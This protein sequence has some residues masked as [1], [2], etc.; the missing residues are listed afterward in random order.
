MVGH[1]SLINVRAGVNFDDSIYKRVDTEDCDGV[2][3]LTVRGVALGQSILD[4]FPPWTPFLGSFVH[5]LLYK[6]HLLTDNM[7]L[8]TLQ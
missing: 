6:V 1:A 5:E 2:L 4:Y 7:T 3:F 8:R